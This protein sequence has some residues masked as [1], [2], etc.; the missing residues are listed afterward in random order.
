MVT[1]SKLRTIG[2]YAA[3]VFLCLVILVFVMKLWN[4]SP[5]TPFEYGGDALFH[6]MVIKGIIDN[7]WYLRNNLIGMPGVADVFY[8][9][10]ADNLHFLIIKFLS[11]FTSDYALIFNFYF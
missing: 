10:M 6:G 11:V 8:F 7:G 5:R 1:N 2:E 9:P 4:A 3:A